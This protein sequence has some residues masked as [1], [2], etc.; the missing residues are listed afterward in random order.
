MRLRSGLEQVAMNAKA[1]RELFAARAMCRPQIRCWNSSGLNAIKSSA[2]GRHSPCWQGRAA[3]SP[4]V[5][6]SVP[7]Q[8]ITDALTQVGELIRQAREHVVTVI[9]DLE[10]VKMPYLRPQIL[11]DSS[12]LLVYM[13]QWQSEIADLAHDLTTGHLQALPE[14]SQ[15]TL[16]QRDFDPFVSSFVSVCHRHKAA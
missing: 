4:R 7:L 16:N 1:A 6:A 13:D 15:L 2:C 3:I 12:I 11:R 9:G 10:R 5:R 8:Q 14:F